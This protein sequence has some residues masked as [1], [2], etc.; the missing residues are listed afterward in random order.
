M[1]YYNNKY[2]DEN[3][4]FILAAMIYFIHGISSW[5]DA[6]SFIHK[7]RWGDAHECKRYIYLDAILHY[8]LFIN[9]NNFV[10]N[11]KIKK[12]LNQRGWFRC[13]NKLV[14]S[15]QSLVKT[16]CSIFNLCKFLLLYTYYHIKLRL[17]NYIWLK[18]MLLQF[19][20][21]TITHRRLTFLNT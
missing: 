12:H 4:C 19:L 13:N 20:I 8:N 5:L 17:S 14:G 18:V 16:G 7:W 1:F 6:T 2:F 10:I 21:D 9:Y 15:I 11:Y 3:T